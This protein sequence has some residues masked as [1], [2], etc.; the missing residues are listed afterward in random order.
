MT[1]CHYPLVAVKGCSDVL[2]TK[3]FEV[4]VCE[5]GVASKQEH[6]AYL[7]HTLGGDRCFTEHLQFILRQIPPVN[8]FEP[9]FVVGKRISFDISIIT[10]TDYYHL[11]GLEEF[12]CRVLV[13]LADSAQIALQ[14]GDELVADFHE[15]NIRKAIFSFQEFLHTAIAADILLHSRFA[16]AYSRK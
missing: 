2:G 10:G 15:W 7:R 14:I 16:L 9:D 12:R 3:Q 4:D 6:I 11:E 13:A 8:P 1:M 5:S